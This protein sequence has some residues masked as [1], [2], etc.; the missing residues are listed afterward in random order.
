MQDGVT[1]SDAP[2]ALNCAVGF[3]DNFRSGR[4]LLTASLV[5]LLAVG[6]AAQTPQQ[7]SA[8]SNPALGPPSENEQS[9]YASARAYID[10]PLKQ[11]VKRVPQ[12]KDLRPAESQ[13]QL[14]MILQTTGER[15]DDFFH[16]VIDLTAREEISLSAAQAGKAV[17]SAGAVR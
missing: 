2:I 16:H 15:V 13:Q 5:F 17:H 3:R 14:L 7:P 9:V 11:I 4:P 10:E 1:P 8:T 12:L 6:A